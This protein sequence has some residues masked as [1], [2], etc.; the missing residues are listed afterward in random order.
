MNCNNDL[1]WFDNI[2]ACGNTDISQTSLSRELGRNMD[3]TEV[4]PAIIQSFGDAFGENLV[5]VDYEMDSS[6]ESWIK[7]N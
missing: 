6:I 5:A 3:I 1:K 7:D 4:L 2:I